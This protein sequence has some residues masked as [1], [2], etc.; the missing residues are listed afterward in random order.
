M[1][2]LSLA[3]LGLSLFQ[4]LRSSQKASS[5]GQSAY[6]QGMFNAAQ[7]GYFGELNAAAHME[8]AGINAA[9][10]QEIGELNAWYIERAGQRNLKM[11]GIQSDE[12]MRRHVRAEKLHAGQIRAVQSGTGIQVNTGSNLRYLHDQIDEGL[13]QRHFLAVKHAETKK[14]IYM[15]YTDKAYATRKS[16]ALQAEA[17]M[18]NGAISADMAMF[19]AQQQ[20]QSYLYSAQLAQQ[21]GQQASSDALWG[22][23]GS[24]GEWAFSSGGQDVIKNIG[25][26]K[27][28]QTPPKLLGPP[29]A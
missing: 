7:A 4:G 21:Q 14:S 8:A 29:G 12:E 9:M 6:N 11:Y 13:R 1:S 24:V 17:I 16:A 26:T 19:G 28:T 27:S 25:F 3:G 15:D 20:Q 23:L 2:W 18:A 5:A 22:M 10:T